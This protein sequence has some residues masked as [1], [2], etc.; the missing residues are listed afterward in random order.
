[1]RRFNVD[2]P[3]QGQ[4]LVSS[5]FF[6]LPLSFSVIHAFMCCISLFSLHYMTLRF[7]ALHDSHNMSLHMIMYIICLLPCIVLYPCSTG[8]KPTCFQAFLAGNSM[9][10]PSV[11]FVMLTVM[12]A[13]LTM[14]TLKT[15][16]LSQPGHVVPR[17][18][19]GMAVLQIPFM[20]S[21]EPLSTVFLCLQ[22]AGYREPKHQ[23][24]ELVVWFSV[25]VQSSME[26]LLLCIT[27][28][29][30]AFA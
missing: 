23:Q 24:E 4:L 28:R 5:N 1:M 20:S 18:H 8:N 10:I 25:L 17:A 13:C 9:D 19:R 30:A 21:V 22:L 11:G 7:L 2:I 29:Y 27:Q 26:L 6:L 16:H 14:P 15:S 12:L 3:S